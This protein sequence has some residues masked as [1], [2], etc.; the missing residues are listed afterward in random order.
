M[1]K[2]KK[3]HILYVLVI[4]SILSYS[5]ILL[6]NA[7][8]GRPEAPFTVK[9]LR[10]IHENNLSCSVFSVENTSSNLISG[11]SFLMRPTVQTIDHVENGD[12]NLIQTENNKNTYS[13]RGVFNGSEI[14]E[15]T[16]CFNNASKSHSGDR[17]PSTP[18][19]T[20]GMTHNNTSTEFSPY[21]DITLSTNNKLIDK[22]N[23]TGSSARVSFVVSG[24][25]CNPKFGSIELD[26]SVIRQNISK[27]KVPLVISFGGE[28]GTELAGDSKCND[29]KKLANAYNKVIDIMNTHSIDLDIEG[30]I[31][32]KHDITDNRSKA[33]KIL[34]DKYK[35]LNITYTL[36]VMPTGLTDDGL[37]VLKSSKN[38]NVKVKCFNLMTM[39]YGSSVDGKSM[40]KN[41]I[42]AVDKVSNNIKTIFGE[43]KPYSMLGITPMIGQNNVDQEV[44]TIDNA[45]SLYKYA[46]DKKINTVSM[47]DVSRDNPCN[48]NGSEQVNCSG[49]ESQSTGEFMDILSGENQG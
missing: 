3:I 25:E 44:F 48:N 49:V 31:L 10:K 36:P 47:W 5:I 45:K 19:S 30:D 12:A 1:K 40:D 14:V 23:S 16:I 2:Y 24:G 32:S 28:S 9:S 37:Y 26:N 38:H 20:S 43:N 27:I 8:D 17:T 34:Q 13:I 18:S 41:A 4:V 15:V 29:P 39:N 33:L 6:S 46:I 22:L 21:L 42:N 7:D 11:W 35:D